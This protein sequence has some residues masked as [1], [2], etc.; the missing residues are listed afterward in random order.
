MIP[1]WYPKRRPD[2]KCGPDNQFLQ[3]QGPAE[4]DPEVLCSLYNKK[5]KLTPSDAKISGPLGV[6]DP[7]ITVYNYFSSSQP[8]NF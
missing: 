4:C 2:G 1:Y 5:Q 6:W 8:L 3:N 7:Y